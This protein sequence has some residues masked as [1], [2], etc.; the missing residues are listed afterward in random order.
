VTADAPRATFD[1]R[2]LLRSGGLTLSLGAMIAACGEGRAGGT[3][4]GRVGE[5]PSVEPLAEGEVDDIVLLRTAQ[6]LEY[7]ALDA[8]TAARGL[9]VLSAEQ[10]TIVLRFI[11]DHT[12]HSVA[13]GGFIT[14]AGGEEFACANPWITRRVITP[15]FDALEGSDDLLRDV[16]NIAHALECLAAASYQSLVGLLTE[17]DLRKKIM[18]IGADENRHAATLAMAIT[19]TP[20]GYLNP[21]LLGE[22]APEKEPEFPIAYAVP[23]TFSMVSAIELVVGVANDEGRRFTVNLQTPAANTFVYSDMSC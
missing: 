6:S 10:E 8:Y 1:R 9:E 14:E 2:Q 16:L 22:P 7:S 15:I 12:G 23:S 20:K 18:Q 3:D 21:L 4:P 19:G 13:L 5:A 11:D 17:P